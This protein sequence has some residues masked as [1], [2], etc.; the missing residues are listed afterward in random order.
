M[1]PLSAGGAEGWQAGYRGSCHSNQKKLATR[2][3]GY[4]P[5]KLSAAHATGPSVSAS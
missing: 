4:K 3:G 2:A 5:H 1:G